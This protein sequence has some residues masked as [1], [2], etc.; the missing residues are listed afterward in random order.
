MPKKGIL[1]LDFGSQYT[2]LIARRIRSHEVFSVILPPS[3][4]YETFAELDPAGIIVSGSP[5]SA[6][7]SRHNLPDWLLRCGKPILGICFGMQKLA[8][9]FG[10]KLG[11]GTHS[12]YGKQQI[13]FHHKGKLFGFLPDSQEAMQVYMSHGDHVASLPDGFELL[14]SSSS[15]PVIAME[16]SLK[17]IYALQFHPEVTHTPQGNEILR[18]FCLEICQAEASWKPADISQQILEKIEQQV[19]KTDQ[20]LLALSGGVDST[21]AA[22]LIAQVIGKRLHCVFIDNGL[23]RQG[24]AQEVQAL[25][26]SAFPAELHVLDKSAYFLNALKGVSDPEQKRKIIGRCFIDCFEEFSQGLKAQWLGQGTI[27][28]DVIESSQ[29]GA[30]AHLIKSHHNVGGLPEKLALKLLEPLRELFKDEVRAIG[31]LLGLPES[32][33]ERH[34]FPGPGLGVRIL[35]AIEPLYCDILRHADRIFLEEL[36]AAGL[37]NSAAQ[38]FAVFLPIKSVGV[39]GDQRA[40]EY[41]IALRAVRTEDFMTCDVAE[42]PWEFLHKVSSRIMNEVPE[43]SRVVYDISSKPPSTIEWE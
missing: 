18:H 14:A 37:Y 27:Y 6:K 35:G 19:G 20:V 17:N 13:R 22:A 5:D 21:V 7:Q 33:L 29:D 2:K 32:L 34:P 38:A 15:C 31:R 4:S 3:I 28:P 24:E 8:E 42:L 10:A 41:V 43:V 1:I 16:D 9:Q 23:M 26:E 30:L 40:Y 12:E 25:F 36:R 39:K 11:S